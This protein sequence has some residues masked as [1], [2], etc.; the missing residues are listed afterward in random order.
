[1]S[2]LALASIGSVALYAFALNGVWEFAQ[3]RPLY[4]CWERWTWGERLLYPLLASVGD[5]LI[6]GGVAALAALAVGAAQPVPQAPAG[7]LVLLAISFAA[8][9]FFEW[10]ARRL[11][12][13]DYR[14]AMPTVHL[15]GEA[16]GLAPV[17]QIT[18]LPAASLFL[19]EAFPLSF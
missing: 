6:V 14:P 19:A 17:A 3:L 7:W 4:T 16:L 11:R 9:L 2:A 18:L 10:T 13:W 5:V 1:V 15:G 12:L 8:S